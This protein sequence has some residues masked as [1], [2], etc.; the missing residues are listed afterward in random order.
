[1][2]FLQFSLASFYDPVRRVSDARLILICWRFRLLVFWD[3]AGH[4]TSVTIAHCRSSGLRPWA[5]AT[6]YFGSGLL[7]GSLAMSRI[8]S[9]RLP[10]P[11]PQQRRRHAPETP[12][13]P[14]S[15]KQTR[16][17]PTQRLWSAQAKRALIPLLVPREDLPLSATLDAFGWSLM[18]AVGASVGGLA[19]SWLGVWRLCPPQT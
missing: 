18:A 9:R 6:C 1:M 13:A 5:L 19:V 7:L 14:T 16:G 15:S 11:K 10:P 17:L 4:R 8:L 2:Q 12:H 3:V